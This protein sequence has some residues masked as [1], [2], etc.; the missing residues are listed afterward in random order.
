[1]TTKYFTFFFSTIL[2]CSAAFFLHSCSN[3]KSVDHFTIAQLDEKIKVLENDLTELKKIRNEKISIDTSG[4][5]PV[6]VV[7][8]DQE[9]LQLLAKDSTVIFKG[10]IEGELPSNKMRIHLSMAYATDFNQLIEVA[11]DGSFAE[12]FEIDKSMIYNLKYNNESYPLYLK[13]GSTLG[14]II[15]LQEKTPLRFIGDLAEENNYNI[16]KKMVFGSFFPKEKF[17]ETSLP[18]DEQRDALLKEYE[19]HLGQFKNLSKEFL[20]LEESNIMYSYGINLLASVKDENKNKREPKSINELAF[21]QDVQ[22]GAAHLFDLYA[23]RKFIF[24]YFD[25]ATD[26]AYNNNESLSKTEVYQLKYDTIGKMF[27]E[28]SITNFLKTDV[29]YEALAKINSIGT[30]QLVQQFRNDVDNIAYQSTINKR[31][32]QMIPARNGALAPNIS[33]VSFQG[34]KFNLKQL[35]GKYVYVFVW[36]TWCA[37][38]KVELPFYERMLEDYGKENIVFLGVSVDK[39]KNKWRESFFYNEYP[40]LQVLVPGDWNSRMIQDYNI[41]SVPQFILIDPNGKIADIKAPRPSKMKEIK[42]LFSQ[43]G[44]FQRTT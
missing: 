35:Q 29:V 36:A 12:E 10:K 23:Y 40:G 14:L 1:M 25:M 26:Q 18:S 43:H 21:I 30:N 37:P 44:I 17:A 39:D 28:S 34:D 32:V 20:A 31:Y 22:F 11:A 19:S 6:A 42:A 27:T 7:N 3:Q 9:I 15:N 8:Q 33:G 16:Q 4:L 2:L 24:E 38:C 13:P 41:G 5:Y